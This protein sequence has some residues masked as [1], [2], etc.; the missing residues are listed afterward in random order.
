MNKALQYCTLMVFTLGFAIQAS[1]QPM[2]SRM[3]ANSLTGALSKIFEKYQTARNISD[4][5]RL[6]QAA[7]RVH[8]PE[9]AQQIQQIYQSDRHMFVMARARALKATPVKAN[10]KSV[11]VSGLSASGAAA[12]MIASNAGYR[13]TGFE[14]RAEYT[15]NIQWTGRQSII[16]S[17]ALI[18]QGLGD[19]FLKQIARPISSGSDLINNVKQE[20]L[21]VQS[22]RRGNPAM[23]PGTA[24][25][26]LDGGTVMLL[27]TKEFE[28]FMLGE[29]R[30]NPAID[31]R[32][33]STM[34]AE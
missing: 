19:R 22:P 25:E 4:P 33:K 8:G 15:R 29:L 21:I 7:R 20:T 16:D 10:G 1:T 27:Q 28:K 17:L 14:A 18:D 32:L 13:V 23:V 26:M 34:T 11:V 31:I 6:I 3:D 9:V 30:R 2:N 12:A 5:D 24:S